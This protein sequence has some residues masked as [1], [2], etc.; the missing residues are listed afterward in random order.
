MCYI[1]LGCEG[2]VE[3]CLTNDGEKDVLGKGN[4]ASEN[5]E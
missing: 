2:R 5:K 4:N 3:V 1:K